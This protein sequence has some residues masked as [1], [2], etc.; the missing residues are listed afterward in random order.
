MVIKK[1]YIVNI[2]SLYYEKQEKNKVCMFN[3]N[4]HNVIKMKMRMR[5]HDAY[6]SASTCSS[7]SMV[8][9]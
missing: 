3:L 1:F 8:L 4:S 6:K 9:R 5:F 2:M 7:I